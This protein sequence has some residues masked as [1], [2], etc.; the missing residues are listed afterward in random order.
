VDLIL[1]GRET[2]QP[3]QPSTVVDLTMDPPRIVRAGRWARRV[4]AFLTH[5]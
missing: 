5:K 1:E 4:G 2:K 3:S